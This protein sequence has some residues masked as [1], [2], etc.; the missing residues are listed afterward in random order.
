MKLG[1]TRGRLYRLAKLGTQYRHPKTAVL[2]HALAGHTS[3]EA[4]ARACAPEAAT[5]VA[6][7]RTGEPLPAFARAC[8]IMRYHRAGRPPEWAR[9]IMHHHRA[10]RSLERVRRRLHVVRHW[11]NRAEASH[12]LCA[13]SSHGRAR[14]APAPP[15]APPSACGLACYRVAR[16]C[17]AAVPLT[18]SM[19]TTMPPHAAS[20]DSRVPHAVTSL[21]C[22]PGLRR[23]PAWPPPATVGGAWTP[24]WPPH[25]LRPSSQESASPHALRRACNKQSPPPFVLGARGDHAARVSLGR[26]GP[27]T[28]KWV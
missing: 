6:W 8:R 3:P 21:R 10:T 28:E 4:D 24:T 11:L 17:P 2:C 18:A 15:P 27:K 9:H 5:T 12:L 7:P 26:N 19:N 25:P 13:T 20:P 14:R 1:R 22:R 16:T 23:D